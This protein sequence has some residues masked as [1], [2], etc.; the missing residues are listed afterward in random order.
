MTANS[1]TGVTGC[2]THQRRRKALWH[3]ACDGCDGCDGLSRVGARACLTS[4]H[5][6]LTRT[7]LARTRV[8]PSHPSHPSHHKN[9]K[10]LLKSTPSPTP[11]HPV[12]W[13][14]V[15]K[16]REKMPTVTA[17]IDDLR[18]AFGAEVINQSIRNG[19]AG[20]TDFWAEENGIC[21]GNR[22][23]EGVGITADK[24]FIKP[25]PPE[26]KPRGRGRK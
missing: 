8:Y 9:I 1:V 20:G 13:R 21:V 15:M 24:M 14:I 12:T 6:H 19:L 23:P 16:L 17:W 25:S 4:C 2:V 11:S 5:A 22:K 7:C 10:G 18:A 26:E 3:K